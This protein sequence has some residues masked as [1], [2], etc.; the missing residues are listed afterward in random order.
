MRALPDALA[1]QLAPGAAGLLAFCWIVIRR[2]GVSLGFTDHDR[3]LTLNGVTCQAATG[4]TPGAATAELGSRP[5]AAEVRGVLDAQNLTEADIAAGLYDRASVEAWRVDWT[6]P[7]V[8]LLLWRGTIIELTRQGGAVEAKIGGP[9]HA[10]EI[11]VGRT[12]QRACDAELGDARCRVDVTKPP[13]QG[14]VCDKSW[15]TCRDKFANLFN[16]Q[17][18]LDI[19]GDDYLAA[20]ASDSPANT[21]GSRRS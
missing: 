9:L 3:P 4:L 16:F 5:G 13:Y 19:P 21:G 7:A 10:L 15:R 6:T 12:Y 20:Y 1:A 18:F 17:G 14:A 8:A 11:V 2:D